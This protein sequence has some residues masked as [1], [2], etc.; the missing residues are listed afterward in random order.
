MAADSWIKTTWQ[1]ALEY[2]ISIQDD[3]PDFQP[4]REN[5]QLLIPTFYQLGFRGKELQRLNQCRLFLRISWLS[6][7]TTGD[8]TR[9][10][11]NALEQP[12][13]LCI[14]EQF[15]YPAQ[16]RPPAESWKVWNRALA[17]LCDSR[18]YLKS[19][20]GNF[21]NAKAV[22]WWL[23]PQSIR[24]YQDHDNLV[25]FRKAPGRG[26][27]AMQSKF[28]GME[29][30]THLPVSK[31]PVTA[32]RKGNAAHIT[33][34][35]SLAQGV[36]VPISSADWILQW[37]EFPDNLD[38]EWQDKE[39]IRAVSDGSFKNNHGTAAWMLFISD[40]CIIKGKCVTPG[41]PECQSA[42]R[43]ELAGLYGIVSTVRYLEMTRH[44]LGKITVACDGLSALHQASQ[45]YDFVNP[46]EPQF[47]LIMAIHSVVAESKWLVQW[48]HVKGHQDV[49]LDFHD[50]DFWGHWNTTMD[51]TAKEFWMESKHTTIDPIIHGEPWR[52][53]LL[54]RKVTSQLRERL[55][56]HCTLPA[57]LGY[58]QQKR[59]FANCNVQLIDWE[60]IETAMAAT[61]VTRRHW[62]SKTLSGFCSTGVM[63]RKRKER[64]SDE[65][66][67][68]GMKEDVEHIW[69][70]SHDTQHIWDTALANL[71]EWMSINDTYLGLQMMIIQE[72]KRWRT[73]ETIML[74]DM[75]PWISAVAAKQA[76]LGWNNFFEGFLVKDWSMVVKQQLGR[77]RSR[78][79]SRRWTS[80][81]IR[82]LWQIA[83]DLWE[84]RNGYL[85][86]RD[87]SVLTRQLEAEIRKQFNLGFNLLDRNSKALFQPGEKGILQKPIEIKRQ[88]VRRVQLARIKAEGEKRGAYQKERRLL[89]RWLGQQK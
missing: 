69:R 64:D 74:T 15:L 48:R 54:G 11:R 84:H 38:V 49:T 4:L 32:T 9:I 58:W 17:K 42:F 8:G 10:E 18:W 44:L 66:P 25:M 57:A 37:V 83:W 88:W 16:D 86:A 26:T 78:R 51:T 22:Q 53:T 21:L 71:K 41:E 28:C 13:L 62:I 31:I 67:R 47:D 75:P 77:M 45:S 59:R 14:K 35:G 20:L 6:E 40:S 27:R 5:D 76:A 61:P 33:G 89:A 50:L 2:D 80:A 24:L 70:C 34:I 81:L 3:V 43:S 19:P 12:Y 72:L 30:T 39:E 68:C 85:H 79:S 60:A 29:T 52:T 65:C 46:N 7:I 23:D 56:E 63:M 87:N 1:F 73:E 36:P 55:R 82:K